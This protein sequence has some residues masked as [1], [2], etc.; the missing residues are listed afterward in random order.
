MGPERHHL[1]CRV[2]TR[3]MELKTDLS[4][5]SGLSRGF[6]LLS[7]CEPA[8]GGLAGG[9]ESKAVPS[10]LQPPHPGQVNLEDPV[11][12]RLGM[13]ALASL[14][15]LEHQGDKAQLMSQSVNSLPHEP[16]HDHPRRSP[17]AEESGDKGGLLGED[18]RGGR[19][20]DKQLR[21]L[22]LWTGSTEGGV[23]ELGLP[24]RTSQI[25]P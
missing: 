9:L 7:S 6:W 21:T 19:Q 8:P 18:R 24:L 17:K 10:A 15:V 25:A 23:W 16:N 14:L 1:P 4:R 12:R 2:T 5:E 13:R 20:E 22:S 3:A 11:S